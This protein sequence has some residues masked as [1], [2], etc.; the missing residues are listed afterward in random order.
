[1]GKSES[2]QKKSV[3]TVVFLTTIAGLL[4][5]VGLHYI[6]NGKNKEHTSKQQNKS[7]IEPVSPRIQIS[8]RN[9]PKPIVSKVENKI[10]GIE[11]FSIEIAGQ[12]LDIAI[13]PLDINHFFLP[14]KDG[15][16]LYEKL[17]KRASTE[18]AA[19]RL[20]AGLLSRCS[21]THTSK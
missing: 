10:T 16:Y 3:L 6:G 11:N 4:L 7:S 14:E 19:A 20:L 8:S 5:A 18:P 13:S 9:K 21:R 15:L 1:M 2:T 12:S 17:S